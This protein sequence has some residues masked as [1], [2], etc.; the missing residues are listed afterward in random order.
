METDTTGSGNQID[1][2]RGIQGANARFKESSEGR[3]TQAQLNGNDVTNAQV[4]VKTRENV[5]H[6][7]R[8]TRGSQSEETRASIEKRRYQNIQRIFSEGEETID[9][10]DTEILR[11]MK[12]EKVPLPPFPYF[13]F[14]IA[15][16]KDIVDVIATI[17][18]VGIVLSMA[19]SFLFALILFIW[20]MGKMSGGWWK[21][22]LINY[23]LV[24][25]S[26][27]I[28]IEFIPGVNIIPTTTIFILMAHYRETKIVKLLNLALEELH[29]MGVGVK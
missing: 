29:S 10:G 6:R 21:K 3:T 2:N 14:S 5:R 1:T 28:A 23:I 18:L 19:L 16:L 15:L 8:S 12:T 26:I 17:T 7:T 25:Y 4:R 22:K 11:E 20:T 13:I 27:T 9:A 24:R